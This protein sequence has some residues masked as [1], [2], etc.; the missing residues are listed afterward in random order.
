MTVEGR[1][2]FM[3][4]KIKL[5]PALMLCAILGA[6]EAPR[7]PEFHFEPAS[8]RRIG[9]G[10]G[11]IIPLAAGGKA[12]CEVVVPAKA[13]PMLRFAGSQLAF[14][15]GNIIGG[16][17]A[18]TTKSSGKNTAFVLGPAGAALAGFDPVKLDR[19]GYIIKTVG[20]RIVIAGI[21]DPSADPAKRIPHFNE[22]GTLN[23][24]YEFLE[25]FGGVRFYFP[26]ET[27][28][29]VPR[30]KDWSIPRIDIID[31][32]DN[33]Y[34]QIYYG[35]EALGRRTA[36]YPGLPEKEIRMHS[37]LQTRMS[38]LRLPFGHG[39]GCLGLVQR[40][41]KTHPEYFALRENGE[42]HNGSRI[43]SKHD[44]AGQLCFSSDGLKEEI[45][46][47][48]AA[49]LTGKPASSRGA[50]MRDGRS[51]WQQ[52][53]FSRPFFNLGPNDGMYQCRCP[54]CR[55][56]FAGGAQTSS[57]LVWKFVADIAGKLKKNGV[58]GFVTMSAYSCY[59]TIPQLELPD[60]ILMKYCTAGPWNENNPEV[61]AQAVERLKAWTKKAGHKLVL[62]T[63]ICKTSGKTPVLDIPASTPRA[64]GSFFRKTV[65]YISGALAEAGTDCW[66]FNFMNYYV[67]GKVMWDASTD[68]DALL[69]EHFRLM[70][71]P[72]AAEMKAFYDTLERHWMKD[73]IGRFVD[74]PLGPQPVCPSYFDI[75]T[76]IYSPAEIERVNRLFDRAEKKAENDPD[77]LKRVRFMR[78]EM[79]G[80]VLAGAE[81]FK[82]SAED[83]KLRT[84]YAPEAQDTIRIDG[85][86]DEAAWKA[87]RPV[88]LY[89]SRKNSGV[90]VH[91]R[92]KMLFDKDNYYVGIEC[93]EPHTDKMICGKHENDDIEIWRDNLAELL[94]A[95]GPRDEF[96]YQ[97]MLNSA[98][99]FCDLR[100][101]KL[102]LDTKW[103]SRLE[104]KCSV[105]PGK[106][107]IAEVRIPRKSMPE[108]RD[109][110]FAANF[111]RGRILE[112]KC[113]VR[114]LHYR[115]SP[116]IAR[117]S[118]ANCGTVVL[119]AEP[120]SVSIISCGDFDAPVV[121]NRMRIGQKTAWNSSAPIT[122]D[123]RNFV[124]KG[125]SVRLELPGG[126]R[127]LRQ[128]I[129]PKLLKPGTR[130]RLSF[131]LKL[132]NV[133]NR[134]NPR[135][136]F[137]VDIR[138]GKKGTDNT[139]FPLNPS[140]LGTMEWT[141]Y[142]FEF[143]IPEGT[144][145]AGAPHIGFHLHVDAEG[146]VWIDHVEM[147]PVENTEK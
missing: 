124:T 92:V 116:D 37:N 50:L 34:R 70:Y 74:T 23:G 109:N 143:T 30:K 14:Y 129:D 144:G 104:Y 127:I 56:Q 114:V 35:Q 42:R 66:L 86:L 123:N 142:Q 95:S 135:S 43:A 15:L 88:W 133:V 63:Y 10:T 85:K 47:D 128:K 121:R 146:K 57:N 26:G 36:Y 118:A 101:E 90:E 91:T 119:G 125:Q 33:P 97:I 67:F 46:Q 13:S 145:S 89:P 122:V 12:L 60:N 64:V 28:T 99:K 134:K 100:C 106:G 62:H 53:V 45:Y 107:W 17:V 108:I 110:T 9:V 78:K 137:Y 61:Q 102:R 126:G 8:P 130:Y 52:S 105:V 39:L 73:I 77:A 41:G 132:E 19:D 141:R 48:A 140:L 20:N 2:S 69:E 27:G 16:K 44:V 5:L 58:P 84:L 80:P 147:V 7:V 115:W 1:N 138:F 111:S 24:V 96:Y 55:P 59:I 32:P 6:S 38:T 4:R 71:G 120:A 98:G 40:F 139:L 72:A 3:Q 136:G 81:R 21:D 18:V 25:R 29:Y 93:D 113:G 112:S 76:K 131:Y 54:K 68:A 51:G 94:F 49:F 22:R 83:R 79:W 82:Q 11:P 75:W 117:K 103:N 87:A 31:R 65:P